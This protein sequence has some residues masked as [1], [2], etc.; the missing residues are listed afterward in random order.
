VS[1]PSLAG[2]RLEA[3]P[4]IIAHRGY[5]ARYPE[6]TL[7]AFAAAMKAGVDMI[8]L[9][10]MLSKDR[11]MV[12]IHDDTLD[13][14][15]NGTGPVGL[16]TLSQL[17]KLDAGGWFAPRFAGET[18][19]TLEEAVDLLGGRVLINIEIKR[20]AYEPN[21]PPDAVERQL[22]DL[23]KGRGLLDSVLISSFEGKSLA[24]IASRGDGV[25]LAFLHRTAGEPENIKTCRKLQAFSF[26]PN[27]IELKEEYVQRF[28]EA[29]FLVFPYNADTEEQIRRVIK[30][31]ADG[32]ITSDPLLAREIWEG[33]SLPR[34]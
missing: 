21:D 31:G 25:A 14:T 10:V 19:P 11:R 16:K 33:E 26:H 1:M 7:C 34:G 28:H 20:S 8:E 9:D 32:V 22:L 5:R 23:V 2:R 13:R 29:G 18:L 27:W 3:D 30:T 15:T 17:K 4:W 24:R 12:V 6:N